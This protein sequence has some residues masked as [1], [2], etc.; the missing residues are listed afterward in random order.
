[1]KKKSLSTSTA[2][3]ILAIIILI[4]VISTIGTISGEITYDSKNSSNVFTF[5]FN[6]IICGSDNFNYKVGELSR[7]G[8]LT[9]GRHLYELGT[10]YNDVDGIVV[11]ILFY[12]F[13]VITGIVALVSSIVCKNDK[14]KKVILIICSAILFICSIIIFCTPAFAKKVMKDTVNKI[15]GYTSLEIQY[16]DL[17]ISG[18][19]SAGF[20][21]LVASVLVCFS[22]FAK[23][24]EPETY[25]EIE[26]ATPVES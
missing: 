13:A 2:L 6:H 20:W 8:V 12:V 5:T 19:G 15:F 11:V 24:K 7:V 3:C 10:I 1:M 14:N 9:Q 18:S 17:D 4:V 21:T 22:A 16:K 26:T 23:E 25:K